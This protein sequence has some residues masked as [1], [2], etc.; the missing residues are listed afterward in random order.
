LKEKQTL[1]FSDIMSRGVAINARI[2]PKIP[3]IPL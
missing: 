1:D 3:I 2:I